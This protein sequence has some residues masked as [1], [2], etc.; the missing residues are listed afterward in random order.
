LFELLI[1]AR[2][3]RTRKRQTILSVLAIGLA[4]A[5]SVTALSLQ[6][7][8]SDMLFDII[9]QDL[10][11][12]SVS[13]KEGDD[14][15]YLYQNLMERIDSIPVVK[16]ASPSLATSAA[17]SFKDSLENVAMIGVIPEDM[18]EIYVSIKKNIIKG[19]LAQIREKNRVMMPKKLASKLKVKLGD[20][21]LSSFPDRI[22]IYLTL[23][24]IY[25]SPQG[26]PEDM[27]FVSLETA[28]RFLQEGDVA[29]SVDIKLHDIY[30]GDSVARE[31]SSYGYKA[32]S[33]QELYPDILRTLAVEKVN[34]AITMLLLMI[35]ASFGI[36]SVMNMLVT[37]KV[38]E[39]GML[40]AIGATRYNILRIFL[41]ES[42]ILGLI[43]GLLGALLGLTFSLY[44]K[45][46][47]FSMQAP[48]GQTITLPLVIRPLD[49]FL[50][51]ALAGLLS[52]IAGIYPA[53]K[54]ST[55]DPVE[56]LKG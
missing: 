28:R 19:D 46:M 29:S 50:V 34:N 21:I 39:I 17:F 26:F 49:V 37:E 22:P 41:L 53:W 40:M 10:P 43:G 42:G 9:I 16:D 38:R 44:L 8:F 4:V 51:V 13:P 15:I 31:I 7:G 47:Q 30:Q 48:G 18:G 33:W 45:G 11:H 2:H 14:Y 55:L 24:A 54:A 27:C 20:N 3:I 32:K 35:I 12:V 52:V 5:I 1:A 6:N 36:A 56:A 25:D 23:V